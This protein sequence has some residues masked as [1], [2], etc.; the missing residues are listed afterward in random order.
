MKFKQFLS[1]NESR[2][3]LFRNEALRI[4]NTIN[5][6]FQKHSEKEILRKLKGNVTRVN[7]EATHVLVMNYK[8]LDQSYG[9]FYIYFC[10]SDVGVPFSF[11]TTTTGGKLNPML[12]LPIVS[13][14]NIESDDGDVK[15]I[16][17]NFSFYR[18][19]LVHELIHF[20]DKQRLKGEKRS[21]VSVLSNNGLAGYFNDPAEFNAFYQQELE[22][23][24]AVLLKYG[25]YPKFIESTAIDTVQGFI[26]WMK[27]HMNS[28]YIKHLTP[29][30]MRKVDKRLAGLYVEWKKQGIIPDIK[31]S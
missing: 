16:R 10:S 31:R 2:D 23:V 14:V 22:E 17:A 6:F 9:D 28:H 11:G 20:F 21:S 24:K 19:E 3:Q 25:K 26:K 30:N 1:E 15:S 29:Q 5:N 4:Y 18:S 13:D 8:D 7:G 27:E 12:I